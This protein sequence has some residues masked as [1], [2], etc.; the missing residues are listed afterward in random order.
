MP[1]FLPSQLKIGNRTV[2]VIV[3]PN[4]VAGDGQPVMGLYDLENPTIYIAAGMKPLATVETFWHELMHAIFD[5]TRFGIDMQM[6][7]ET[8]DSPAIDA[9]KLEE[10]SAESF[11]KVFLQVVQDNNIANI[12]T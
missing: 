11:A 4:L 9:Y 7:M 8:T 12:T 3:Q 5:Y 10:R 6:E 2:P 1:P